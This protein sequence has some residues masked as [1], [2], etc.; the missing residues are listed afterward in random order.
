[1][2]VMQINSTKDYVKLILSCII[3]P[4][5][6]I[7]MSAHGQVLSIDEAVLTAVNNNPNISKMQ[8]RYRALKEIPS[9][10]GSLPDPMIMLNAMNFPTDTFN[11]KQEPMTQMQIGVSQAFP[12]PGK[13]S[14]RKQV[15]EYEAIAA[16]H[17]VGEVRQQIISHV[18]Q[19]WWQL[20]FLDRALEV[21]SKN[22][23]LM[24]QLLEVSRKK[25]EV[26]KGLQQDVLL[27][28]LELS[29]LLDHEIELKSMRKHGN[30]QLNVL[31]DISPNKKFALPK[32]M[33]DIIKNDWA[34]EDLYHRSE[35]ARSVLLE[36][37]ELQEAAKTKLSLSKKGYYPDF[38][39]GVTYGDRRGD[40]PPPKGGA[41]ADFLSIMLNVNIPIYS[42]SK[43][44]REISQRA[45]ELETS[46]YVVMDSLTK[47]RSEVSMALT[48]LEQSNEQYLLFKTGIVPQA[49]Q[50][51]SSM[52]SAYQVNKVDF[53]NLV[54][55]QI[56]LF[57]YELQYWKAFTAS[58][59]ALAR[60]TAAV[61]EESVYE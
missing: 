42:G 37:K 20:Y 29:K 32:S 15:S 1:M 7:S 12:F 38:K 46:R 55:S 58:Q 44:S 36:K 10:A 6:L 31:M 56:T 16:S 39:L 47:V 53:L 4:V 8:A 59:Q 9:Q 2:D 30:I 41:R 40:N 43:Q 48:D 52:L 5:L 28:Q 34:E 61:G 26:G 23:D 21:V 18:K 27:A 11:V 50:T 49:Q 54:R 13:L 22:Q 60:L 3:I 35:N 14:L 45:E 57:N 33:P 19:S 25:Y 51:V 17:S 24:R